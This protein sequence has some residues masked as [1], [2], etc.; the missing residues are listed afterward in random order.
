MI[1]DFTVKNYLSIKD[2][3]TLSFLATTI[4]NTEDLKI[5]SLEEGK[6]NLYSF[7]SIYGAN[8]SG[9]SNIIKALSDLTNFILFSHRLD[10]DQS[11]PAYNPYRLDK[12]YLSLPT[13]FEIEF[14]V[15]KIR[16]LYSIEFL[17][18]EILKEELYFYPERKKATLFI[19]N[20]NEE[21]KYGSYF[22]GDKKNLETFLLP[23]RLL[24]S[25]VANSKNDVLNTVFR[26]FRDNINIHVRMDSSHK[27]VHSTT[28]QLRKN[29]ND[30][31]NVLSM[32]LNAADLNIKD[33][34]LIEDKDIFDK[35]RIPDDI[36]E[37]V[38][39]RIIDDVRYKPFLGH[40]IYDHGKITE[41]VT[42]FDLEQ[43]ESTGTI[44]MYDIAGEVISALKNGNV[45][46]IDEFNSG[47][48]P[49]LNKFIVELF[50][51]PKINKNNAQLLISTH[52][53]CV[54]DLKILKR[55]QIWFTNK[56]IDGSTELFCLNEFDIDKNLIRDNSKYAKHYLDGRFKAVPAPNIVELI[57]GLI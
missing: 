25:V 39:K 32:F 14:C 3:V 55:E 33:V 51:N 13:H 16:Y 4:K 44:K 15:N 30:F 12:E 38:K 53:T 27:P 47:L 31:K 24:L 35:I 20:K 6:Y 29:P 8:A 18:K 45:L 17:K 7:S 34:K 22:T 42:F 1:I 5:I 46:I 19:R 49:L 36:P 23:N 11:I 54:L 57:D 41:E 2:T 40:P 50:I 28:L 52:D 43:E 21:I 26:F 56:L 48:H 9:K 37:E 10:L